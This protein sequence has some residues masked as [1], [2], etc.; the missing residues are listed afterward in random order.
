MVQC[1]AEIVS[2][3]VPLLITMD[4]YKKEKNIIKL[5]EMP[6]LSIVEHK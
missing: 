3:R 2:S 6:N 5:M 1:D 4:K